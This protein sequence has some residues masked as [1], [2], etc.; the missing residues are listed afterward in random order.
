[1][2]SLKARKANH[3]SKY[4]RTK[5]D[6]AWSLSI[7]SKWGNKCAICG[8]TEGLQAHHLIAKKGRGVIYRYNLRNGICLCTRHHGKFGAYNSAH[9]GHLAFG[10][11]LAQHHPKVL[12]WVEKHI[13]NVQYTGDVPKFN[14][15]EAYEGLI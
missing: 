5:A 14:Y 2:T 8:S 3:F 13:Q 10:I 6:R 1:M 4:W 12:D 15:K 9:S 7:R 11:W